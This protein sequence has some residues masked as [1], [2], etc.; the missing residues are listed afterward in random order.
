MPSLR[1][2]PFLDRF[3]A[4]E[5]Q[6]RGEGLDELK[7][8]SG[9]MTLQGLLQKQQEAQA[10]KQIMAQSG[11][12]PA[13]AIPL[14]VQ[15][16]NYEAA[17]KLGDLVKNL[18]P[19]QY[20]AMIEGPDGSILQPGPDGRIHPVLQRA[21]VQRPTVAPPNATVLGPDNKTPLYTAP[22]AEK[23]PLIH[24][25]PIG[26][27]QVQ[28]HISHDN[29]QTWAPV[30]GSK[31]G[32]KFAKQ[33][34]SVDT[35]GGAQ[36]PT[37]DTIEMDAYRYVTDGTLPPNMGRGVQGVRQATEIRNRAAQ[38][39]KDMGMT[40]D[41]I[42]FAQLTN[43]AQVGAIAQLGRARAQILQFEKTARN[44]ADLALEASKNV[45]RTGSPL[46]NRPLQYI[47]AEVTGDPA[48][49]VFNAANETFVS[50]YARVMSGGYGAAQT[51]EGAQQRAHTLLSTATSPAQYGQVII[52]LKREMDNRVKALNTQMAEERQRLRGGH[53]KSE[54]VAPPGDAALPATAAPTSAPKRA[55]GPNGEKL[56]LREG[57]WVP[58]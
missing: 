28:P 55:T 49:K 7:Q 10:L 22:P 40:P 1:E 50:E 30:P 26:D 6:I 51:T 15:S 24:D 44:N 13:K 37:A 27:N 20:G 57:R 17:S 58:M 12:D 33:V 36:P 52:Q 5:A 42:R 39:A 48:A 25:L 45:W 8:V 16:G 54:P 35:G 14:L 9:V 23:R 21:P 29:G 38:I 2:I 4:R 32:P 43:K 19:S 41:E 11:G 3:R 56:E 18:R 34:I 53:G 31:P 46:V 47:R